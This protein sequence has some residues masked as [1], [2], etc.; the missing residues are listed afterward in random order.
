MLR[1][2]TCAK[3]NGVNVSLI[4]CA[5]KNSVNVSP[6]SQDKDLLF[7]SISRPEDSKQR[8]QL[9][10]LRLQFRPHSSSNQAIFSSSN[11]AGCSSQVGSI[12]STSRHQ[13]P[14]SS[15]SGHSIIGCRA[16]NGSSIVPITPSVGYKY[17]P[18]ILKCHAQFNSGIDGVLHEPCYSSRHRVAF[19]LGTVENVVL[20]VVQGPS[21]LSSACSDLD[22]KNGSRAKPGDEICPYSC[23]F[24]SDFKLC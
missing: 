3:K 11:Q 16:T 22:N 6:I 17:S 4:T 14:I 9:R 8:N 23:P 5:K 18:I 1:R 12:A 7:I 19:P 13:E 15:S 20:S 21:K 2:I 24:C 10:V